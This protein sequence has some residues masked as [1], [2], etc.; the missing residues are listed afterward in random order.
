[1]W[2]L[3]IYI[4]TCIIGERFQEYAAICARR[5]PQLVIH[6]PLPTC[7]FLAIINLAIA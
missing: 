6:R 2:M 1:M 5:V 7:P 3:D 4:G